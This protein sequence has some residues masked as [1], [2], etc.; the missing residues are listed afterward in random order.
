VV[1]SVKLSRLP[2]SIAAER[3]N[4]FRPRAEVSDG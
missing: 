3:D 2:P 4:R 1:T